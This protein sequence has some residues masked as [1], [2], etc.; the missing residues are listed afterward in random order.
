MK[1]EKDGRMARMRMWSGGGTSVGEGSR[2]SGGGAG[3]PGAREVFHSHRRE[4]EVWDVG[5]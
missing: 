2:D 5:R 4:A 1:Q 3:P